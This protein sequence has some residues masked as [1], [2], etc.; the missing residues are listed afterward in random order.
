MFIL[1]S[2]SPRRTELLQSIGCKFRTIVSRA[3]ELS[4]DAQNPKDLAIANATFKAKTVAKEYP[5]LPVLGADTIVTLDGHIHYK[6]HDAEDARRMLRTLAGKTHEVIT[7]IAI[8]KNDELYTSAEV[9]QVMFDDMTDDEIAAYVATGEPMDKSGSYALQG[10]AGA[11]IRGI[12]G[13]YSNVVGL[14]LCALKHLARKAA[15]DLWAE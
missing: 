15:V 5:D 4:G 2:K 6:P 9:T 13:S 14:P 10:G 12:N 7:G 8:V 1:A 11:F 3:E